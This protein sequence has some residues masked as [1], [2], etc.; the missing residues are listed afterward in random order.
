MENLPLTSVHLITT[1]TA[2]VGIEKKLMYFE[3][4]DSPL[5][6]SEARTKT[7]SSG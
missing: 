1:S 4:C 7:E 6:L 2:Y 3:L 5:L